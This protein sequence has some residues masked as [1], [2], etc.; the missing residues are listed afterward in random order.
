MAGKTVPVD[1]STGLLTLIKPALHYACPGKSDAFINF[2][3]RQRPK[4]NN[5]TYL[6]WPVVR[7]LG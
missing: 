1:P 5:T 7:K 4:I 2:S 3:K 6:L